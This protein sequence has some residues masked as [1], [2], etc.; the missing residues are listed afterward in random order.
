M[1][2]RPRVSA[3]RSTKAPANPAKSSLASS[4]LAGWPFAHLVDVRVWQMGDG[5]TVLL[6]VVLVGLGCLVGRGTG[7]QSTG[8]RYQRMLWR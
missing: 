6:Y 7:N 2:S 1:K 4:W 5:R 3:S 8:P